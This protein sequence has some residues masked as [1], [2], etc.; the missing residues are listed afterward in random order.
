GSSGSSGMGEKCYKCDVCGKEFS[1]SSH[2]Q[3]HQRV[4]TGEKPSGPSS[5]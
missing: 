5:G 2:L 4:H 3:T 1:Q